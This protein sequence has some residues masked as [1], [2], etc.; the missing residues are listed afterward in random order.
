MK[1]STKLLELQANQAAKRRSLNAFASMEL[2]EVKA[3][4]K[5]ALDLFGR[6]HERFD[7]PG[8]GHRWGGVLEARP[9]EP[10]IIYV[11]Y[12]LENPRKPGRK[13]T[14]MVYRGA[15][16]AEVLAQAKEMRT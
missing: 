2:D 15:T 7:L 9:N 4:R 16:I 1:K 14:R 5:M 11:G 12:Y 6:D 3:W 13:K 8:G 10:G